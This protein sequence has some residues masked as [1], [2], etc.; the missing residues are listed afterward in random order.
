MSKAVSEQI[1]LELPATSA[2]GSVTLFRYCS[3]DVPFWALPNT[4]AGRWNRV[5]DPPT[6]YWSMTPDA[7]W[8]ELIRAEGLQHETDLDLVRMPIWTCRAPFA[9]LVDLRDEESAASVGATLDALIGDDWSAC[10][11]LATTLRVSCGGVISPSAALDGHH[12]VTLFGPRRVIDWRTRP[13][14]A[15]AVPTAL[16]SIGRPRAGLVASVRRPADP[17]GRQRLF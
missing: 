6:Q 11:D 1:A 2:A 9:D 5:G 14:L 12:N 7:V 10:Q 13:A 4:R 3:Y 15:S 16:T 17:S 8:A